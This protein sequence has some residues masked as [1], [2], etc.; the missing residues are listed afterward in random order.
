MDTYRGVKFVSD[1]TDLVNKEK[2]EPLISFKINGPI[3]LAVVGL[4]YLGYVG[5]QENLKNSRK[6]NELLVKYEKALDSAI[7]NDA[8]SFKNYRKNIEKVLS[9]LS[10]QEKEILETAMRLSEESK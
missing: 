9:G 4:L 1:Q 2:K 7:I 3:I 8:K 10:T 5:H 6:I